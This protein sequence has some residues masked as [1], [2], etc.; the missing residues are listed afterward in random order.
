MS[1]G[2]GSVFTY[3]FTSYDPAGVRGPP[4]DRPVSHGRDVPGLLSCILPSLYTAAQN[5]KPTQ[6]QQRL[7]SLPVFVLQQNTAQSTD[8]ILTLRP[9]MTEEP[10]LNLC[11]LPALKGRWGSHGTTASLCPQHFTLTHTPAKPPR[12]S[13][14]YPCLTDPRVEQPP[15][16]RLHSTLRRPTLP[17]A[18]QTL[19]T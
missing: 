1:N 3:L 6:T 14:P 12:I 5:T 2:T 18:I 7:P 8:R 11:R 16:V 17:R 10:Q 15:R 4:E 13:F 19:R 9:A